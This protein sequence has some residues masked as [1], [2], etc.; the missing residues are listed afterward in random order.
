M[1]LPR[2]LLFLILLWPTTLPAAEPA[3]LRQSLVRYKAL[4]EVIPLGPDYTALK[5]EGTMDDVVTVLVKEALLR[6]GQPEIWI[7]GYDS[8]AKRDISGWVPVE[9]RVDEAQTKYVYDH[10]KTGRTED[11]HYG[12]L[13]K[14]ANT[15]TVDEFPPRL[16][17]KGAF[18]LARRD[19]RAPIGGRSQDTYHSVVEW[20]LI[21]HDV[22]QSFAYKTSD[23]AIPDQD[24][25]IPPPDGLMEATG[26]D[27][28]QPAD[29]T[30]WERVQK[31]GKFIGLT[32]FEHL[33]RPYG[34]VMPLAGYY[35]GYAGLCARSGGMPLTFL[36]GDA[37]K[38]I[39][40]GGAD[41]YSYLF[42]GA[43]GKTDLIVSCEGGPRE[44]AV[45]IHSFTHD[46]VGIQYRFGQSFAEVLAN[47]DVDPSAPLTAQELYSLQV[48]DEPL[49]ITPEQ[50]FLDT[51]IAPR[52]R[53][54]VLA[55]LAEK[56]KAEEARRA[57]L[58]WREK[59]P[60]DWDDEDRT[61]YQ[62]WVRSDPKTRVPYVAPIDYEARRRS[63]ERMEKAYRDS[64]A[65]PEVWA[66][67]QRR[68]AEHLA[69]TSRR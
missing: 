16:R 38:I 23:L 32:G 60:R 42:K 18:Q 2:I 27:F 44:F 53:P 56:A 63:R 67:L 28:R 54:A 33:D 39:I 12:A 68:F 31:A 9:L 52:D 51:R 55:E 10:P 65:P 58:S 40:P 26:W 45:N 15:G 7:E 64:I 4:R 19:T 5:P 11:F 59:F 20:I 43:H 36:R 41:L 57:N 30:V 17:M 62:A 69:R 6:G 46:Q 49:W 50:L 29:R 25:L 3:D 61:D 37:N 13:I 24:N 34:T 47:Q 1:P 21:R 66:D 22:P 8:F 35:L 14:S 48:K